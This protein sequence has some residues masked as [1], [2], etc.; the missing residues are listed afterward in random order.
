MKYTA[1][2][3]LMFAT[4]KGPNQMPIEFNTETSFDFPGQWIWLK[5]NALVLLGQ[6]QNKERK[7]TKCLKMKLSCQR[8]CSAWRLW[9][10]SQGSQQKGLLFASLLWPMLPHY[11]SSLTFFPSDYLHCLYK[12]CSLLSFSFCTWLAKDAK[13]SPVCCTSME[14]PKTVT[15]K[16]TLPLPQACFCCPM[17]LIPVPSFSQME[18]FT[19][20][21]V[22][23]TKKWVV[24]LFLW[25]VLDC[26]WRL[27]KGKKKRRK[28]VV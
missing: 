13:L 6:S 4:S 12:D 18:H 14:G 15:R 7:K 10:S 11:W 21:F 16:K 9:P 5:M 8:S 28:L 1:G 17:P 22:C 2:K 3:F 26:F 25:F 23:F 27:R 20:F 24:C 19:F